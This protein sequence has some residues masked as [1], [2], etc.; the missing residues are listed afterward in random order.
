MSVIPTVGDSMRTEF[1]LSASQIGLLTSLFMVAFALGSIPMGVLGSRWG[2]KVL[3]AGAGVMALGAVLFAFSGSYPWFLASRFLQGIGA[4]A[5]LPVV[6]MLIAQVFPPTE[7]AKSLG[8]FGAGLGVGVVAAL[9]CFPSLAAWAGYR[10]VFLVA[11]GAAVAVGCAEPRAAGGPPSSSGP[12]A[13]V[14]PG[15]GPPLD[16]PGSQSPPTPP[17]GGEHRRFR[18]HRGA[19]GVDAVLPPRYARSELGHGRVRERRDKGGP[20]VSGTCWEP[21]R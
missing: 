13:A 3:L 5:I 4:S 6:N 19:G 10:A 20:V 12:G 9:L 21:E 1:S 15:A 17:G 8:L 7:R 11:A 2:G 18:H 16:A 14:V